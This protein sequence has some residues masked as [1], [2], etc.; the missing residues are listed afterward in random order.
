[1]SRSATVTI[2]VNRVNDLPQPLDSAVMLEEG[3]QNAIVP[4]TTYD[5]DEDPL[6]PLTYDPSFAKH[7][8]SKVTEWPSMAQL[9]QVDVFGNKT[10]I[11]VDFGNELETTGSAF[12]SEVIRYSSQWSNC[13][14]E[15]FEW[16][17]PGCDRV[18]LAISSSVSVPP[19]SDRI[20]RWGDEQASCVNSGWDSHQ[21]LG[22]PNVYP[23]FA[24]HQD[25]FCF[26]SANSGLEWIELRFPNAMYIT[27]VAL[28]EV[29]QFGSLKRILTTSEYK[30]DNTVPCAGDSC[31][32]DTAWDTLWEGVPGITDPN[33]E[34]GRIVVPESMCPIHYKS[35]IL[36]LEFDTAAVPG[37]N[38]FDAVELS[39][40]ADQV[41]G[42][43]MSVDDAVHPNRIMYE[44]WSGVHGNDTFKFVSSDCISWS[45]EPGV[46]DVVIQPPRGAFS[47]AFQYDVHS[48]DITVADAFSIGFRDI[49][50]Q[51]ESMEHGSNTQGSSPRAVEIEFRA[52]AN[53]TSVAETSVGATSDFRVGDTVSATTDDAE[54]TLTGLEVLG[55]P[56]RLEFWVTSPTLRSQ[57]TFR[58]QVVIC[59][60]YHTWALDTPGLSGCVSCSHILNSDSRGGSTD[61]LNCLSTGCP[62]GYILDRSQSGFE[63][64]T[65]KMCPSGKYT[66]GGLFPECVECTKGYGPQY[67]SV[68]GSSTCDRCARGYYQIERSEEDA[69]V[70]AVCV[71]CDE[72]SMVCEEEGVRLQTMALR[73]GYYRYGPRTTDVRPCPFP[74]ACPGGP[75][76]LVGAG[77]MI[78]SHNSS[79]P[80][81]MVPIEWSDYICAKEYTGAFCASCEEGY[82]FS[83]FAD[84]CHFCGGDDRLVQYLLFVLGWVA[85]LAFLLMLYQLYKF[86][87]SRGY[88]IV[89]VSPHFQDNVINW[90]VTMQ[91][92]AQLRTFVRESTKHR[93]D[94]GVAIGFPSLFERIFAFVSNGVSLDIA[95]VIRA[96]CLRSNR[97]DF[98]DKIILV[99]LFPFVCLLVQAVCFVLMARRPSI[100]VKKP[101]RAMSD[102]RIKRD[103][104]FVLILK[105]TNVVCLVW[106][107]VMIRQLASAFGCISLDDGEG[108]RV[109][110]LSVDPSMDC[111]SDRYRMIR[112]LAI[113]ALT[114]AVPLM[115]LMTI[116]M[117]WPMRHVLA[118]RTE[119]TCSPILDIF[120][121]R[122]YPACWYFA[123]IDFLFRRVVTMF[124]LLFFAEDP[125]LMM[126]VAMLV[127]LFW[128]VLYR[129]AEPG[130]EQFTNNLQTLCNWNILASAFAL[131]V[132]STDG[133]IS[134]AFEV[135]L[136]VTLIVINLMTIVFT[137][138]GGASARFLK[139]ISFTTVRARRESLTSKRGFYR[140][141][142]D[143]GDTLL[144]NMKSSLKKSSLKKVQPEPPKPKASKA[145]EIDVNLSHKAKLPPLK[146]A[147]PLGTG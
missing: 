42:L 117:V 109:S 100:G 46:V 93:F 31:S 120:I 132:M 50:E 13:R 53:T 1:M 12:S 107:P 96:E 66:G 28:Y 92:V 135:S 11:I 9:Y 90:F 125:E 141:A 126:F 41:A 84:R 5:V 59:P 147:V 119:R 99:C 20:E 94:T 97:F 70:T 143:V 139:R 27:N 68:E 16:A 101:G 39:G 137:V 89:K 30:D 110:F 19:F 35:D 26:G 17:N 115:T 114:I 136:A 34:D 127:S 2:V 142:S 86:L 10:D 8:Y 32:R 77:D 140:K 130:Y 15:C 36:R 33:A 67:S 18:G 111:D 25:A 95:V 51:I 7:Q 57:V 44:P 54:M 122:W 102:E 123:I 113:I 116:A 121:S 29:F 73:P 145:S 104:I 129:E 69:S 60:L 91:M 76:N 103:W 75:H 40:T 56:A 63:G 45:D 64:A 78:E 134:A 128:L 133:T 106:F 144:Q 21:I 124:G 138:F 82:Y 55:V 98:G 87:L 22:P 4:L 37:W 85:M 108:G 74:D 65:C 131:Q 72:D 146:N 38:T 81:I 52:S 6:N 105:Y 79:G 112:N 49:M 48:V 88:K 118:T 58:A 14:G 62:P 71:A 24:C 83:A 80:S 47:S 61:A 43:V 23:V 3:A